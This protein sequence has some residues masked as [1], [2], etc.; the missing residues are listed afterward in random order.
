[1]ARNFRLMKSVLA[2][3]ITAAAV[4]TVNAQIVATPQ[5]LPQGHC[6]G[7]PFRL[8]AGEANLHFAHDDVLTALPMKVTLRLYDAEGSLVA[9]R[10]VTALPARSA[11][12]LEFR[13][14]GLFYAQASFDAILDPSGRRDTSASLELNDVDGLRVVIP[15]KCI[16][17][18][19]IR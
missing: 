5:P 16:P 7:G 2:L 10:T 8:T 13:G 19:Y 12:T 4:V 11:T 15:V 14:S 3:M 18:E 9:S 1:M 6:I 17:N